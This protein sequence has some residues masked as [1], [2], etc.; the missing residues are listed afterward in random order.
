MSPRTLKRLA[1]V[2]TILA[3]V[4]ASHVGFAQTAA[5]RPVQVGDVTGVD[6]QIEGA[7]SEPTDAMVVVVESS[8]QHIALLVDE[9]IGQQQVVSKTLD[10]TMAHSSS[11]VGA[12][13]VAEGQVA[14]ILNV[15]DLGRLG[16]EFTIAAGQRPDEVA[17]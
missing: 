11:F 14:L 15:D 2:L 13:I 6:L 3:T 1:L 5:R 16:E 7:L 4:A 9:I 12:A 8:N 10:G 17:A